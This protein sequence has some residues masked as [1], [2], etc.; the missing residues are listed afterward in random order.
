MP[1][2]NLPGLVLDR[3]HP[4]SRGLVGWWP[5][6]E[7]GGSGVADVTGTGKPSPITTAS[8]DHKWIGGPR[9][10]AA[11]LFS[12]QQA[13]APV[14]NNLFQIGAG[15]YALSI[16]VFTTAVGTLLAMSKFAGSGDDYWFGTSGASA[17]T[18]SIKGGTVTASVNIADGF[19]H[20]IAAT[21]LS[22]YVT[23]YVD[24]RARNAGTLATASSP[25]GSFLLGAFIAAGSYGWIGGMSSARYY[26]RVLDAREVAQLYADPLAGALAPARARLYVA[27]AISPPAA[28]AAPPT[29][30]RL[31]N[32]GYVGRIFRRGEK[33]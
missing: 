25:T 22:G 3:A 29:A 1:A 21:R 32:R 28:I 24:G 13:A 14:S 6:N 12:G 27:P 7:G 16:W 23:I 30:D 10:G 8:T 33:G 19:W 4:L 20:H 9:G 15:D 11:V 2:Q 18:M 26:N 31:W 5:L 17:V